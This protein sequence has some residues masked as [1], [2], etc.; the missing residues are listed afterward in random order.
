[1][2]NITSSYFDKETLKKEVCEIIDVNG[3]TYYEVS[4]VVEPMNVVKLRVELEFNLNNEIDL[5]YYKGI[6]DKRG[7]E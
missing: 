3:C 5:T 2:I 4:R 7:K 1:M 6:L